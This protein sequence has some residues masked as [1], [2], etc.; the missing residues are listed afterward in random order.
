MPDGVSEAFHLE[1]VGTGVKNIIGEMSNFISEQI[2][3]STFT[4]PRSGT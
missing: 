3:Y 1:P 4:N 2:I